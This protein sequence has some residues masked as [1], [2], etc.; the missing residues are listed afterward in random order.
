[1]KYR[2]YRPVTHRW[3]NVS[4]VAEYLGL[5]RATVYEYVSNRRIPFVKIPKSNQVRFNPDSIDSWMSSGGVPTI[6]EALSQIG[7]DKNGSP[8]KA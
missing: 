8:T 3:M 6:E 2:R 5:S 1:M 4:Q 7:D